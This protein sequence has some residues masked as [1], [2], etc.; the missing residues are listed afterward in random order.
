[1]PANST[2][3]SG[4]ILRD[5]IARLLKGSSKRRTQATT[6]NG[7]RA[8]SK[9]VNGTYAE[10]A[11]SKEVQQ[12]ARDLLTKERYVFILLR[13]AEQDVNDSLTAPAWKLLTTQMA[14]IPGGALPVIREDLS[15][16]LVEVSA[17]FIDRC[18]V[19][20]EQYYRFVQ[21]GCYD[22]LEIW[23]QDIWPSL[24]RFTDR[25]GKPGPAEWENGKFPPGK[26]DH[27][28]VGICWHEASAYARWIGKRLPTA[29]E[30]QKAGGWPEPLSGV[31]SFCTR[32]P[33]GDLFAADRANLWGTGPGTTVS[34]KE[35]RKGAT[36]NGIYQMS[37]NVWE[38]LDDPLVA[39]PSDPGETFQTWKPIRRIIGGAFDTYLESEATNFFVTG[40]PE[41]DR[42]SN[43]GFRCA[44]S[45][46]R[47]R[48]MPVNPTSK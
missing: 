20:N 6:T 13:E 48:P 24:M 26:A 19:T 22:D 9:S 39:I 47:L 34:I 43:I 31:N 1:M 44:I 28:V 21:S 29:A 27:P 4:S 2:V 8:I 15:T 11:S 35:F 41:L 38:W 14:V 7:A 33:W 32:Y 10:Q 5:W 23:P 37:G 25:T 36:P 46:D 30:W 40:Q 45:L 18:S 42:R 17:F 12:L 3:T 16:E